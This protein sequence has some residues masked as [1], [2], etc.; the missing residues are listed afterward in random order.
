MAGRLAAHN[1]KA[2]FPPSLTLTVDLSD[3]S[4]DSGSVFVSQPP[5]S[6]GLLELRERRNGR[7]IKLRMRIVLMLGWARI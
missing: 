7:I 2:Q 4:R 3:R 5:A 6:T 1:P